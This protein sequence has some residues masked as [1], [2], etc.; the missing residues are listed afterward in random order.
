MSV[1]KQFLEINYTDGTFEQGEV[2]GGALP[3]RMVNAWDEDGH[4]AVALSPDGES[5]AVIN[6]RHV[7]K[8]VFK[9]VEPQ[10][11]VPGT[12]EEEK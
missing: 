9:P 5:Y 12:E 2:Y 8:L 6:L 1:E 11:A 3:E 7:R 4:L 10:D